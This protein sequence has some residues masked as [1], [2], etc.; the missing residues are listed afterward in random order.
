MK[1]LVL[2]TV[3]MLSVAAG[4]LWGESIWQD[5][6]IYASGE[7]L[8]VGDVLQVQVEDISRMRFN[9]Q[10][11]QDASF[12]VSSNPDGNLTPFLPPVQ[13]NRNSQTRNSTAV[14]GRGNMTIQMAARV[15]EQLADGKYRIQGTRTYSFSGIANIF[16]VTGI[17]DPVLLKGRMI[18]SA[19]IANMRLDI[20]GVKEGAGVNIQRPPLEEDEAAST[21]LTEEEKQAI[22]IDY[23]QKMIGEITQ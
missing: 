5:R 12:S 17:V 20:R 9:L 8:E 23:L 18:S 4:T 3:C 7:N 10:L 16:T 14:T 11:T 1:R 15:T 22:I 19:D 2:L 13:S 6:N 21:K